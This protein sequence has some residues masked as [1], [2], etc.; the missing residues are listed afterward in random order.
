MVGVGVKVMVGVGVGLIVKKFFLQISKS[1]RS[2]LLSLL[3]SAVFV[4]E[5]PVNSFRQISKSMRSTFPSQLASPLDLRQLGFV[6]VGVLVGVLVG[7]MDGQM[8]GC[9]RQQDDPPRHLTSSTSPVRQ[10]LL[11][12]PP[13][14][15]HS[16]LGMGAV[17]GRG[18]HMAGVGNSDGSPGG[19]KIQQSGCPTG[20]A[21]GI[22]IPTSPVRQVFLQ[23]PPYSA[24][25]PLGMGEAKGVGV[26][27]SPG[28]PPVPPPSPSGGGGGSVGAVVGG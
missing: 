25:S 6:G 4:V 22:D 19:R 23:L 11:Q 13:N 1:I 3:K 2:T 14:A 27:I 21:K 18:K 8:D 9:S 15:A 16:S 20:H 12:L 7:I 17:N 28:M 26:I 10:V 5:A 24:H